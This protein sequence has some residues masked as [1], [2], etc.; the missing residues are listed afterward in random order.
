MKST[1][2]NFLAGVAGAGAVAT[3]RPVFA[4]AS[5]DTVKSA[6]KGLTFTTLRDRG[7]DHLGIPTAKGIV[8]VGMAAKSMGISNPPMHIDDVVVGAGDIKSLQ[9]IAAGA[10]AS[11][12]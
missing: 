8:D 9:R 2:G 7:V 4:A 3:A 1:R 12:L 6:T 10:P 5:P 11:A